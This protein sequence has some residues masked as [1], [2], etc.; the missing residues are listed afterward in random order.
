MWVLSAGA[1]LV[2]CKFGR[3]RSATIVIAYLMVIH[4]DVHL[5]LTAHSAGGCTALW[6]HLL[7]WSHYSVCGSST[8]DATERW[9]YTAA[10]KVWKGSRT[11]FLNT[12][13]SDNQI[14]ECN[15][16]NAATKPNLS[17]SGCCGRPGS[18]VHSDGVEHY[19]AC[20]LS[21]LKVI[22]GCQI[23]QASQDPKPHLEYNFLR[24]FTL[25]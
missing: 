16:A 5:A 15:A 17:S 19:K 14:Y 4:L 22:G 3:S 25:S 12:R 20:Q 23:N 2:H 1:I 11:R 24:F 8:R 9:L 6:G 10:F 21:Q 7:P 18:W 13:E